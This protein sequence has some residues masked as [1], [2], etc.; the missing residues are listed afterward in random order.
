M[1]QSVRAFPDHNELI[2][3]LR[4]EL[5]ENVYISDSVKFMA[6]SEESYECVIDKTA[7]VPIGDLKAN[8][9]CYVYTVLTEESILGEINYL[10]Q[11]EYKI[12][13]VGESTVA[14]EPTQNTKERIDKNSLIVNYA[15][16]V[17][18]NDMR[19]RVIN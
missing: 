6:Q 7:V 16:S 10:K 13:A 3:A 12:L 5:K 2:F 9:T 4:D 19:V 14:I 15:S 8:N 17:L 11:G 1:V 18:E